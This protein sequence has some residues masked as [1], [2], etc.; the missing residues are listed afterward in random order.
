MSA[1]LLRQ[2]QRT[3]GT[4]YAI[5]RELG[6]GGMSRVF[7]ATETALRRRVVVKVLP[8][9]ISGAVS[10][11]RFQREIQLAAS[12]QHPHIVPVLAAGASE[13]LP[14][15][16][17]PFEAGESLRARIARDGALPLRDVIAILRDVTQALSYA[18]ARGVVHRDIKPDNILLEGT[19]GRVMVTDFG[20]AK[21]V[22]QT[23]SATLTGVGV[24]IG[25]PQYMSPEQAAGEREI[26]GRSDLYSLGVVSYQMV[27]GQL[28]FNAPTV[29]GILMK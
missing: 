23:S 15:F 14:Y 18:H 25:T 28:P 9:E 29:A 5:E 12:L 16:T 2:L 11:D 26:D 10:A 17:M 4:A 7:V 27:S 22:S 6:G 13:G 19:R 3:L 24:A 20:I 1:E 8:P 21:A